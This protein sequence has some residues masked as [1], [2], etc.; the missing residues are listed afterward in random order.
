MEAE[1]LMEQEVQPYT[2]S[3]EAKICMMCGLRPV[4]GYNGC[5]HGVCK[6]CAKFFLIALQPYN[7]AR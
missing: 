3:I 1:R 2:L 7:P 6:V 4:S 5:G